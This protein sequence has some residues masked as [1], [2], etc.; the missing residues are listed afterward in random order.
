MS[1]K[2]A[3]IL[4]SD[5]EYEVILDEYY[6]RRAEVVFVLDG[7]NGKRSFTIYMIPN[8]NGWFDERLENIRYKMIE[9]GYTEIKFYPVGD[10]VKMTEVEVSAHL[11]MGDLENRINDLWQENFGSYFGDFIDAKT[12]NGHGG[13]MSQ[14]FNKIFHNLINYL[15]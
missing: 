10:Y 11:K 5:I 12:T 1:K 13:L 4:K 9:A 15:K 3:D 14:T 6:K 7:K 8:L 2:F